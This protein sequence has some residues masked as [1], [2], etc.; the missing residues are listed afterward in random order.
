MPVIISASRRTDIPAH[1]SEWFMRRVREGFAVARNP[2][3][4]KQERRVS[5]RP[6]DVGA[7]VFWTKNP[8]PLLPRLAELS[9]YAYY[10][11][12]TVTSYGRDIEPVVPDKEKEIIPL[13]R[14]LAGAIGPERV[15]WRYDP[16]LIS[17]RYGIDFHL[18]S[19]EKFARALEGFTLRCVFSYLDMYRGM[20]RAAREL[21]FRAPDEA[22]KLAL[23]RG[24]ASAAMAHG[25]TPES[26]AED[27]N[28]EQFGINHTSCIDAALIEKISG[29]PLPRAKDKNQRRHCRC[30]PAIDIGAYDTCASGCRY[31]YASHSARRTAANIA[32]H[33]DGAPY[34]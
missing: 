32:N 30:A 5:L 7:I 29:R 26:C 11:Q 2:M 22:E 12:F 16:V 8:A 20:S 21:G 3:N 10:F 28:L 18:R 9:G 25:I 24:L 23:A 13:F 34:L 27:I 6:E 33:D 14:R 19:F 15:I 31:C 4:P 17:E 1:W